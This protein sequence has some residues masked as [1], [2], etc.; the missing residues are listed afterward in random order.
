MSKRVIRRFEQPTICFETKDKTGYPYNMFISPEYTCP[1]RLRRELS[2][3]SL[4]LIIGGSFGAIFM[5]INI[6]E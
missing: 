5:S 6:A 2:C 4:L 3:G 1:D